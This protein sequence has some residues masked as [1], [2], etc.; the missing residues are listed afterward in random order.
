MKVLL[1]LIILCIMMT[2]SDG[3]CFTT[4]PKLGAKGCADPH[5]KKLHPPASQWQ[6]NNCMDCTCDPQS[7]LNCCSKHELTPT[8]AGMQTSS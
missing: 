3:A 2:L 7:Q 8:I 5:D 1:C 6:S 4:L